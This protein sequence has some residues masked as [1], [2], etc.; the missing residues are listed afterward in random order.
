MI[1]YRKTF[2]KSVVLRGAR[3]WLAVVACSLVA[4]ARANETAPAVAELSLEPIVVGVPDHLEIAPEAV[5]IG[6]A[7]QVQRLVVTA[8]YPEGLLQDVTRAATMVSENEGVVRVVEGVLAPTG[9][10][11]TVV[12]VQVGELQQAVPVTVSGHANRDPV[13]FQNE[14][15]ALLTRQ[16]CNS[17]GCHGSPSGKGGF[18]LSMQAYDGQF[19]QRTLTREFFGRRVNLLSAEKSL[20]LLKPTMQIAHGGGVRL[21]K[22]EHPYQTLR[23]WIDQGCQVDSGD[24]AYCVRLEILPGLRRILKRPAHTQQLVVLA[25]LSDG[26]VRD[27]TRLATFSSSDSNMAQVLPGGLVVGH[28]RGQAAIMIRYLQHVEA[29]HFT[30][31]KDI[32]G[33]VWNDPPENN[34]IDTHVHNKLRQLRYLPSGDA[35]DEH[36]MRRVY[37]TVI[38]VLPS[39]D[40]VRAFLA[41]PSDDKRSRLIDELLDRPEYATFW[42]MRW[43][44][45][46]QLKDK[47]VSGRGV[48]KYHKWIVDAFAE[49][50]PFDQ[51]VGQLL[52]A[53]GSTFLNPPANYYR[54]LDKTDECTEA[55]AQ[56]FLG[57]R[58]Q[59]AKCHNHPFERWTQDNYYGLSA[60]FNRVKRKAGS[61]Q[62][63][64]VVWMA[65]TGEVTQPRTQKTMQPWLPDKGIDLQKDPDRRAVFAQWLTSPENPYFAHVAVN[66]LWSHLMGRGIVE[67]VDDFRVTN[68]PSNVELLEAL[69]NDFRESRFDQKQMLRVILN[70]RTFQRSAQP[71]AFNR[72]D[73]KYFS[74]RFEKLLAAEQLLDAICHLTRI[75]ENFEGVPL[76]TPATALANPPKNEFMKVFGQPDRSTACACERSSESNLA[77]AIQ[78]FNGPLIHA[79]LGDKGNRFHQAIGAEKSDDEVIC[80][81]YL[82]G[83]CRQPEPAEIEAARAH[84][85]SKENRSEAF[86]DICWALINTNEFLMQH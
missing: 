18:R 65:S 59:C 55:T 60:F 31:V 35:S 17:G 40:E 80:E 66:R 9:D 26:T 15:L 36:F 14:T 85:S 38:G 82:A 58:I 47:T 50:M 84:V 71:N 11:A 49:N 72:G 8:H 28:D 44:D 67:P 19:D 29:V 69:A 48:S 83:L 27:V 32:E 52:T 53:D 86:E 6:S 74:R 34:Y 30:F 75:P 63:E 21:K 42:T 41:D 2:G 64:M 56:L 45:L 1:S 16:G 33:F 24:Q 20:L 13:S 22:G 10:G 68:P 70:S 4:Y 51:F 79:K 78:L 39:V 62:D 76:G 5:V 23:D 54:A 7:R 12:R 81:L 73:H 25:H 37:L 43:A 77:Q 61:R 3:L 57:V 46:L